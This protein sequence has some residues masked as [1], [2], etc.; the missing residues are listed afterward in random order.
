MPRTPLRLFLRPLT[1]ALLMALPALP[2]QAGKQPQPSAADVSAVQSILRNADLL[3]ACEA[4]DARQVKK[5][6]DEGVDPNASRTSGATAL[7]YAVAGKHA[8]VVHLLLA[9]KADPN[10]TTFGLAPLFLAAENGDVDTVKLLLDAG[11][12]VNA[13]LVAVDEEMKARNGDTA[14]MAAA[15]AGIGPGA[16]KA[17]LAAGA[18]VNARADD[19]KTAVMQAVASENIEV[20]RALL[21]AKPDVNARMKA[22][23]DIDALTLAVGKRRA[24]MVALLIA[25]GAEVEVQLDGEVTILEFAILSEQP[26]VAALLRKAGAQEPTAARLKMLREAAAQP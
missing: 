25:A 19:G 22:P 17:L 4:G 10:R 12:K 16:T 2:A 14:L 6:L 8:E 15:A 24:D 13:R 1:V 20:L 3:V 26:E 23:E 11:A 18:D 5:L 9:A 7:S 21:V